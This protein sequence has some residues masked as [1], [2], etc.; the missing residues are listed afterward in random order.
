MITALTRTISS[1]PSKP[2]DF[3]C[4][5]EHK[6]RSRES[7]A[8]CEA[9]KDVN[10][11]FR[12]G[13]VGQKKIHSSKQSFVMANFAAQ[14]CSVL[15]CFTLYFQE[16]VLFSNNFCKPWRGLAPFDKAFSNPVVPVLVLDLEL[17]P[18]ILSSLVSYLVTKSAWVRTCVH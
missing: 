5:P 2:F 12:V 14:A 1:D 13:L 7:R 16:I 18:I 8:F 6:E 17:L 3:S 4:C 11:S 15:L 10:K 9:N